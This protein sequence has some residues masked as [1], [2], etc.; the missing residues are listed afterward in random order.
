MQ[1]RNDKLI[2]ILERIR[3]VELATRRRVQDTLAG[4]YRSVF[5]GRGIDFDQI[6]EYVPGD[7]VRSIDWNVTARMGRPYVKEHVEERQ[8]TMLLVVDVSASSDFG[9]TERDKRDLIA[10]LAAALAF[11]AIET[12]DRV[13]LV[14]FS[15]RVER[16]VPPGKGRRHVLRIIREI[17]TI[18]PEG[19]GTDIAAA[20]DFA[21][22]V[23]PKRAVVFLVSDFLTTG[24][25]AEELAK[26]GH[27]MTLTNMRHDL[28]AARVHDPH[29]S[30]LPDVGWVVLEDAETGEIVELDTSSPKVRARF[31]AAN[32]KR[33]EQLAESFRR[34][35]VDALEVR[36]DQEVAPALFTFFR[37]RRRRIS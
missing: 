2:E 15:D 24:D 6:R 34:A 35:R 11:S 25:R 18:E 37:N 21:N 13:G 7:D 8:L 5:R 33:S 23:Q 16:Y 14:L 31:E 32:R 12:D 22:R 3:A 28:V 30:V 17:L 26:L 9:S 4:Q 36:T 20:L 1:K 10:G 29:E 19:R 27:A